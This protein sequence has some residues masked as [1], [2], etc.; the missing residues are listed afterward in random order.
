M[1]KQ[2]R[3]SLLADLPHTVFICLFLCDAGIVTVM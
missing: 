1:A 3:E 2:P